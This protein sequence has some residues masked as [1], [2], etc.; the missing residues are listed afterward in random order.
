MAQDPY[1]LHIALSGENLSL[2]VIFRKKCQMISLH[3]E[4]NEDTSKI[5]IK[6]V[7]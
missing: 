4:T 7:I 5:D 6:C 2:L 3:L 1:K